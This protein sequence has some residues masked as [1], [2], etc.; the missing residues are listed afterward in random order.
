MSNFILQLKLELYFCDGS[1][2]FVLF[3]LPFSHGPE[4]TSRQLFLSVVA[5]TF[6]VTEGDFDG[7]PFTEFE[8]KN[9]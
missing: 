1:E 2:E 6:N 4:M 9:P 5:S 3:R 7:F 8:L